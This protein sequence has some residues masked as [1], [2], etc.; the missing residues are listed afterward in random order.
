MLLET[1]EA[2]A[3]AFA[4]R[5]ADGSWRYLIDCPFGTA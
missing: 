4:R 2:L 1:P 3:A 5:G